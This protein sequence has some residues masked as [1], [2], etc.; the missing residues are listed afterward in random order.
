MS[1]FSY[2]NKFQF[3]SFC[4]VNLEHIDLID[5]NIVLHKENYRGL[6]G[7]PTVVIDVHVILARSSRNMPEEYLD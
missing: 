6:A 2:S 7:I 3:C 4:K 5:S 1:C